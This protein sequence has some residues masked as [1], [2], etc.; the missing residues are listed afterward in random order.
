MARQDI[1]ND[2]EATLGIVPGFMDGMGDM[3]LEHTWSFFERF[4]YGRYGFILKDKGFD[5]Y[6]SSFYL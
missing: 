2:I 3:I 1:I 5:W 6:W 4:S